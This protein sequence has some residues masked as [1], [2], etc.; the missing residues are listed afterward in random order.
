MIILIVEANIL[1]VTT[2]ATIMNRTPPYDKGGTR[3]NENSIASVKCLIPY[4]RFPI[5]VLYMRC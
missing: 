1:I 2:N 4:N 5:V 3:L